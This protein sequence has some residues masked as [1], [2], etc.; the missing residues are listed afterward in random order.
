MSSAAS[1]DYSGERAA[2]GLVPARRDRH[3]VYRA[4]RRRP[5]DRL[6]DPQPPQQGRHQRHLAFRG[7]RR[8]GRQGDR[9]P[10]PQRAVS[11]QPDG[12][13]PR[14]H[15]AEF[16]LRRAPGLA[17]RHAAFRRQHLRGPLSRSRGSPSRTSTF[18]GRSSSSRSTRSSRS[19]TATRAFRWRCSRSPSPTR[20]TPR[21]TT[22]RSAFSATAS[23]RRPRR[24]VS[25]GR[26]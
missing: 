23:I 16:R 14:R 3:R 4:L 24:A 2:R 18:R 20:P 26:A 11:R 13:L 10:H 7:P 6:G 9:R 19:T 21:S 1:F 15:L 12:R 17:R 8:A 25:T 22:P 5:P